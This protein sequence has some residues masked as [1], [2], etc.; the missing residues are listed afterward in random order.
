VRRAAW[1]GGGIAGVWRPAGARAAEPA[2]A[3]AAIRF[4][5]PAQ[6]LG[7]AMV[8]FGRQ[9]G[10]QVSADGPLVAN[11]SS[12]PVQ[13]EMSAQA[14]LSA[15]LAGTGLAFRID[16]STVILERAPSAEGAIQLGPVRVG[17]EAGQ[18]GLTSDPAATEGAGS[19]TTRSTDT[20]TKLVLSLRETP[21]SVSVFTRQRIEDQNLTEI[22]EVLDQAVGLTFIEDGA[23][24]TDGNMVYSRGFPINNYQVDGVPRSTN[25][26]FTDEISDMAL[27]DRIEIVRGA[28][29]LLNGIGDPSATINLVRKKPLQEF[30]GYVTGQVGS[31]NRYRVEGDVS[32][33]LTEGGKVRAR[34]VGALQ[35]SD[36]Y[37][38]RLQLRKE[39]LYG[40]VEVD[41]SP[42]TLLS[43]GV[44]YQNHKSDEASRSGF[45]LFYSDGTP[46][47]FDRS[48]NTSAD[49]GYF[50]HRNLSVFSTLTHHFDNG[51][52]V[53]ADVEQTWRK[54]DGMLGYGV[55]GSLDKDTGTGMAIWP[56]RWMSHLK[57]TSLNVDAS[58]P[59]TL[60][61]REHELVVGASHYIASRNGLD[62]PL[63]YLDGYDPTIGDFYTWNGRIEQPDLSPT[64]RSD[65]RETQSAAFGLVRLKPLD[66]LSIMLGGR[67]TS[68][69]SRD[70]SFPDVGDDTVSTRREKGVF[71]PFAGIVLDLNANISAYASY[72]RIFKPQDSK[73]VSGD[74]LAPLEGNNYEAGLKGEFYDGLLNASAAVFRVE[75]DNFAVI[76]PGQFTP[77]GEQA[78]IGITG[79]VTKGFELE[80]SGE[81][82]PDWKLGGGFT[83]AAPKGPDGE[84]L[85]TYIPKSSV[86]LF[87]SYTFGGA[88]DG[89]TLGANFRWQSRAYSNGVGPGG[90]DFVQGSLALVDLMAKYQVTP[91]VAVTLNV[92]N[93]FD[94]TY[95]TDIS[96]FGYYGEPRSAVLSIKGSF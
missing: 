55:R 91:N 6:P 16:G 72:T 79:T 95:Y 25:Y 17:A 44:E 36:S 50:I 20:S 15:L 92:N 45:P 51:W 88:L 12:S 31:W 74:Y 10:L 5:I 65:W 75:Q 46:T 77:D 68:W 37:V 1:G 54:Y 30:G 85:Q 24:G 4:D 9:A 7:N 93:L 70:R 59:F 61:G 13:G 71:T 60:F 76:D 39:I 43:V 53:K 89:L 94:K 27:F 40:I 42:D 38:D 22:S 47:D 86:K 62:Y 2:S 57:Q 58:G 67:V 18:G 56:G 41:L 69:K 82:L 52:K 84:P 63:W 73:D 3:T 23:L 48:I 83:Y 19:Y 81:L 35:D 33:P 32:V 11:L 21:Q 78:Y 34:L 87:T 26:G 28:T 96:Y 80:V 90:E 8:A 49:W 64:G 14:A 29:G 66:G